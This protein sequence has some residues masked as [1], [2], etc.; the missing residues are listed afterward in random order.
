MA[1]TK[2]CDSCT[3]GPSGF[4]IG[5]IHPSYYSPSETPEEMV[6][7]IIQEERED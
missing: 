7:R 1:G 2:A 6:R 5:Y 4:P 3:N